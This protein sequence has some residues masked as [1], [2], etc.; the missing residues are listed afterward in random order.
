[1]LPMHNI[2]G[3]YYVIYV[4][5]FFLIIVV[6]LCLK[7]NM[8]LRYRS[9]SREVKKV[10]FGRLLVHY[11]ILWSTIHLWQQ[12]QNHLEGD[13][14]ASLFYAQ[15]FVETQDA[16]FSFYKLPLNLTRGKLLIF[17]FCLMAIRSFLMCP[18]RQRCEM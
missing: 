2:Q 10:K 11:R 1:M 8:I 18:S 14:S 9:S 12:T 17:T 15:K 13:L 4:E 3:F 5:E 7:W 16:L 6:W